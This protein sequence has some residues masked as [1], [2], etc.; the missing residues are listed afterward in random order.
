MSD[1][2]QV[3]VS[4]CVLGAPVRYNGGHCRDRD[5][6][7]ELGEH[8]TFLAVCPEVEAGLGAPRESMRLVGR[9]RAPRLEGGRTGRDETGRLAVWSR[10]RVRA[11]EALDLDGFILKKGSPS[12][13][14]ERVRVYPRSGGA[15]SYTGVGVFARELRDRFPM[16]ALE[17][18]GRLHDAGL[19]EHFVTRVFASHRWRRFAASDPDLVDLMAFHRHH[20]LLLRAHDDARASALE[21]LLARAR[22]DESDALLI[23]YGATFAAALA[24]RPTRGAQAKVMARVVAG[25][26]G[27]RAS[28]TTD[29]R[30]AIEEYERGFVPLAVPARLLLHHVRR[31]DPLAATQAWFAPWPPGIRLRTQIVREPRS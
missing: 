4:A 24:T 11:M 30:A 19:R 7:P 23:R 28:E 10:E 8:V 26:R 27:L 12:C 2:P 25:L 18:E 29:L 1:R 6:L 14:M 3:G 9:P 16:L 31:E 22:A 13:G 5:V 17:E 15:P 21:D 20:A